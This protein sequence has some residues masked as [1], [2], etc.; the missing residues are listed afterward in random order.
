MNQNIAG[1]ITTEGRR[2][3]GTHNM[4]LQERR[5]YVVAAF[6]LLVVTLV[7]FRQFLMH[8]KGAEGF[9][10]PPRF[11]RWLCYT[12]SRWAQSASHSKYSGG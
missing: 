3:H 12:V 8:G 11:Y 5:F 9:T 10:I 7:G 4:L 2:A 6:A 1:A